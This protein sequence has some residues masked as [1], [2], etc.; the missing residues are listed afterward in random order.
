M[1]AK[2]KKECLLLVSGNKI[3]W[4]I[5]QRPDERFKI[6]P[7]TKQILQVKLL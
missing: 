2:Q 7:L 4:V 5:G 6:T 1:S 3:A